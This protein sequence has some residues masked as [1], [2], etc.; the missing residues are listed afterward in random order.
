M[1][2]FYGCLQRNR[3]KLFTYWSSSPSPQKEDHFLEELL[4]DEYVDDDEDEDEREY[5]TPE[6]WLH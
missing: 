2:N 4:D 3:V 5:E 1:V 6:L